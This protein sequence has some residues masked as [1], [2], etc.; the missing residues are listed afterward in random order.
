MSLW[1]RIIVIVDFVVLNVSDVSMEM[2]LPLPTRLNLFTYDVLDYDVVAF[3]ILRKCD[4]KVD[5]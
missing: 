1:E 3:L 4:N 2:L 5:F